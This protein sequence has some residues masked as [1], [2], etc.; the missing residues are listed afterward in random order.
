MLACTAGSEFCTYFCVLP[1]ESY[2]EMATSG[3]A[4]PELLIL[5][6][7]VRG[8]KKLK[9]RNDA[10]QIIHSVIVCL[11]ATLLPVL[12]HSEIWG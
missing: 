9:K 7:S 5:V 6:F 10:L 8:L 12:K 2:W 3:V 4:G 1:E 11:N